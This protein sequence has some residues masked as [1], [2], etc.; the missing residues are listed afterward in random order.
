MD[1]VS[2][3]LVQRG[4]GAPE[5]AGQRCLFLVTLHAGTCYLGG[6]CCQTAAFAQHCCASLS[7][8][9]PRELANRGAWADVLCMQGMSQTW[10]R[11][12]HPGI[13]PCCLMNGE[14]ARPRRVPCVSVSVFTLPFSRDSFY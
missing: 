2:S 4:A 9:G 11:A 3:F 13:A 8:Q 14:L 1:G 6:S 10:D 12:V 5:C 7:L